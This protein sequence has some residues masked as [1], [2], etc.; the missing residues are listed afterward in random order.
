MVLVISVERIGGDLVA[1][2]WVVAMRK[3]ST[4]EAS[5]LAGTSAL[6]PP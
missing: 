4:L 5:L 2:K 3:V 6:F 1:F